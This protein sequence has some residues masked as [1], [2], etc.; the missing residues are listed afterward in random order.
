MVLCFKIVLQILY[1]LFIGI[2]ILVVKVLTQNHY[3][4]FLCCYPP[5]AKNTPVLSNRGVM[6]IN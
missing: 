5:T 1:N 2:S 6:R 4:K 3:L